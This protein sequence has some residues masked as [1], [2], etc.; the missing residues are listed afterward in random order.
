MI[1]EILRWIDNGFNYEEGL[2]LLQKYCKNKNLIFQMS[3]RYKERYLLKMKYELFKIAGLPEDETAAKAKAKEYVISNP[4]PAA[5]EQTAPS[6]DFNQLPEAAIKAFRSEHKI[7][8]EEYQSFPEAIKTMIVQKGKL[9]SERDR[10][11]RKLKELS[12]DTSLAAK[13]ERAKTIQRINLLTDQID[14]LFNIIKS[15]RETGEI[16][17]ETKE[18]EKTDKKPNKVRLVQMRNNIRSWLSKNKKKIEALPDG[19]KKT[20][21]SKVLARKLKEKQ[22]LEEKIRKEED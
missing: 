2:T 16:L 14:D 11:H 10:L 1:D 5:A 15:F 3:S 21:K 20:E 22:E 17:Q 18:E 9:Y 4:A 13:N 12:R 7:G 6:K 19:P 8:Y